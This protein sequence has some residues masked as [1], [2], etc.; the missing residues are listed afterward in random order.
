MKCHER[1]TVGRCVGFDLQSYNLQN[2]IENNKLKNVTFNS[3]KVTFFRISILTL[4]YSLGN[5]ISKNLFI[6]LRNGVSK[7]CFTSNPKC[8]INISHHMPKF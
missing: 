5:Q 6:T 8:R 2:T 1:C 3:L 4:F 7:Y